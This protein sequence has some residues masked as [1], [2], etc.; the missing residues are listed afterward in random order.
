MG[1][2]INYPGTHAFA[3]R[4]WTKVVVDLRAA[5]DRVTSLTDAQCSHHLLRKCLDAC[6]VTHLLRS[7]DCFNACAPLQECES[8]IFDG[9]LT[10]I[11]CGL[12]AGKRSQVGL[13][14]WVGGCGV[15]CPM[16]IR[17]AARIAALASYYSDGARGG[18]GS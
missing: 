9:F 16:R 7:T 11:G 10:I 12:D 2:P 17:P 4:Y 14:L 8:V 6:K 13:P 5:I 1:V 3:E 18:G 15:R